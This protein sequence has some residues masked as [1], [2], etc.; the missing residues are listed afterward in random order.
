MLH[1]ETP[2]RGARWGNCRSIYLEDPIEFAGLI[3]R[4][5]PVAPAV[6]VLLDEENAAGGLR[7]DTGTY[8]LV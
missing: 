3:P 5:R 6:P 8:R 7:V 4:L 1:T 2:L